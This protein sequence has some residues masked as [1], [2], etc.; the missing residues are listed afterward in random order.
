MTPLLLHL[1]MLAIVAL[2]VLIML[3]ILNWIDRPVH[4]QDRKEIEA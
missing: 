1:M 3:L 2:K 4:L